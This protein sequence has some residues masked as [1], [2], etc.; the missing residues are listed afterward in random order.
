MT[1][2]ARIADGAVVELFT[3]PTGVSLAQCF[4]AAI[5]QSFVEVPTNVT[6]EQGW[7]FD[8][9]TFRA[10]VATPPTPPTPD[11]VL[12]TKIVAGIAITC[13]SNPALN[14]TF[15]LDDVTMNQIGPVARDAASGLGMPMNLPV[16][17]YPNLAGEPCQFTETQIIAL[18]KAQR[19]LLFQLNTQ[20][21]IMGHSGQPQ[22][23]DQK[24]TIP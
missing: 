10:P 21:A 16:F 9:S 8:G 7:T 18:Y 1:I 17:V 20:A 12:A 23:P 13:I 11:Q 22:W 4:V 14:E 15:A 5:A 3:P 2:Y 6:P 24:A 19:D